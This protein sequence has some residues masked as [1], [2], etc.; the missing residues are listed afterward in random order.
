MFE[1]LQP[2]IP[3]KILGIM[4]AHRADPRPRK[5]DLGVGVYRNE[6]GQTPVFE[7]VRRAEKRIYDNETTKTYIGLEGDLGFNAAMTRV[8]LGNA[9][10]DE[11][12]RSCQ[13]AGGSGA[14][15]ILGDLLHRARPGAKVWLPTPTWPN[16]EPL[17]RSADFTLAR[18]PYYDV[19]TGTVLFDEM[20][21]ALAKA[22]PGDIVLLHG[23]C[24]N[25]SGADLSIDQ[26]VRIAEL[27]S[28]TGFFP[29]VDLAYQGFGEGL[30]EDAA[31]LRLIATRVP[32]MVV[33]VSCSKNFGV[34]R[35]RVGC[36]I[37]V[38]ADG[39]RADAALSQLANVVRAGHSM[40]AAHGASTVR[41][42]LED[43]TLAALW[44]TELEAMRLRIQS[45]RDGLARA[46][47]ARTNSTTYDFLARQRGL[48]SLIDATPAQVDM[49]RQTH[50]I[51]MVDDG[52]LN[53]A[54][55]AERQIEYV[56]E[57]IAAVCGRNE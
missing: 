2:A 57:S 45:M 16:H 29:F 15:R 38:A 39:A 55:L 44:R 12:V 43:P 23:C 19:P 53:V 20:L 35:D 26:W 33:S 49:L 50:G 24:H 14:I 25:P 31:G 8:V 9:I 54:G 41:T 4:D 22:A 42:I 11:R 48:F 40:S 52:R 51:Y 10:P 37:L 36:A 7:A 21:A 34:Y 32:E 5:V 3:D 6:R 46:L 18:Y 13:A 1:T 27:A 30:E 56:A 47:R 28:R 17:M